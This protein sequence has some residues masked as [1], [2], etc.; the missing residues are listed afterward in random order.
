[1]AA[2]K[3]IIASAIDGF[4]DVMTHER[5]GLLVDTADVLSFTKAIVTLAK[6]RE[7]AASYGLCGRQTALSYAWDRVTERILDYYREVK[8]LKAPQASRLTA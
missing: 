4:C 7:L 5:E 8:G 6:D 2:G 3:P 1:M